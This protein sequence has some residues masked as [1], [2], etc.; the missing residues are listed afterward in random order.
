MLWH[1]FCHCN[2]NTYKTRTQ[3]T[4]YRLYHIKNVDLRISLK[5]I[6]KRNNSIQ[7]LVCQLLISIVMMTQFLGEHHLYMNIFLW[8]CQSVCQSNLCPPAHFCIL[9]PCVFLCPPSWDTGTMG[10]VRVPTYSNRAVIFTKSL[11]FLQKV[12]TFYKSLDFLQ[13]VLT[14]YKS[15]DF[16]QKVLTFYKK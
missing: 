12:L 2:Q 11:E 14:F 3:V 6:L 15:L 7:C 4:P 10:G 16:F 8:A 5:R 9:P 13:K 1:L